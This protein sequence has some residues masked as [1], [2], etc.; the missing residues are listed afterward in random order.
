MAADD[1]ERQL[2]AAKIRAL[3][4]PASERT[5]EHW[6]FGQLRLAAEDK[7]LSPFKTFDMK[8]R[9]VAGEESSAPGAESWMFNGNAMLPQGRVAFAGGYLRHIRSGAYLEFRLHMRIERE[10]S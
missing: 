8:W 10:A 9:L 3:L 5:Q 2:V 6:A 1:Q 4:P 7:L